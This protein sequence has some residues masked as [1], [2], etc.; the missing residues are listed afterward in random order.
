[1][2][3][4]LQKD[5]FF[6]KQED[7]KHLINLKRYKEDFAGNSAIKESPRKLSKRGAKK[8]VISVPIGD[9]D[10]SRSNYKGE[11]YP[12][13]DSWTWRKYGQKPIKGSPYPRG[14][15]RCS[16]SKGCPAKKQVE[17]CHHDPTVLL[18]TYSSDHNHHLPAAATKHRH[19]T[20]TFASRDTDSPANTPEHQPSVFTYQPDDDFPEIGAGELDWLSYVGPTLLESTSSVVGSTWADDDVA[21]MLPI[22]EEDQLLFGDLG[23][24]PEC[25]VVFRQYRVESPCCDGT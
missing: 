21:L 4:V 12:P 8:R 3:R 17:R 25:S 6:H 20:T 11:I 9:C 19:P 14:Y 22:G 2:E 10:G 23:E 16:S 5:P 18:I 1:M 15:Y 7:S 13:S 24:L